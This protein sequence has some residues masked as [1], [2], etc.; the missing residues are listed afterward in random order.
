MSIDD[1]TK[2]DSLFAGSDDSSFDGDAQ[3]RL[4]DA[5]VLAAAAVNTRA[6]R[7]MV[8][9]E[10]YCG[11][12][13]RSFNNRVL[14]FKLRQNPGT[15]GRLEKIGNALALKEFMSRINLNMGGK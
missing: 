7:E 6:V 12:W 5:M 10:S 9:L 14:G 1:T 3:S 11:D 15:L 4:V 8:F 13:G 2:L